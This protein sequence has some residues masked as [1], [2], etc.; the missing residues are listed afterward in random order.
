MRFPPVTIQIN[1]PPEA[2]ADTA[3]AGPGTLVRVAGGAGVLAARWGG[4]Q[5]S[6]LWGGD[7]ALG[8]GD[9]ALWGSE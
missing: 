1:S 8:G 4:A 5:P 3:G 6:A 9:I 2:A 7:R